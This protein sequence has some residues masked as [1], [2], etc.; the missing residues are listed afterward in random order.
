MHIVRLD[1]PA[2]LASY[3]TPRGWPALS[4]DD[5]AQQGAQRSLVATEAGVL[6]ARCSLWWNDVPALGDDRLGVIGH[7][8]ALHRDAAVAM[9]DAAR[10]ELGR[11][12]CTR[13]VGPMDGNTWRRYRL[14]VERGA[15]PP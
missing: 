6:A 8:G 2:E 11:E 14:V 1:D 3:D 4:R 5:L 10:T 9:L 7:F 13:A 15:E 12:G